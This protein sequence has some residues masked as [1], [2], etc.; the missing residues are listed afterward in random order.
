MS[1]VGRVSFLKKYMRLNNRIFNLLH[2]REYANNRYLGEVIRYTHSVEKG[3]SLEEVRLGFGL[4]KIKEAFSIIEKY[5]QNAGDMHNEVLVMFVDALKNY[6]DFHMRRSFTNSDVEE[7]QN[8]YKLLCKYVQ[9]SDDISSGGT[10]HIKRSRYTSEERASIEKLFLN[11]HSVRDFDGSSVNHEKLRKAVELAMR[12]PSAC[13]RQCYRMY[14]VD[15]KKFGLLNKWFDGIGGFAD[16]LDKLVFVTGKISVYRE[17]EMMQWVVTGS[18]FASY[19]T[20]AFE[21]YDIGCCFIQRDVFPN[22]K[23]ETVARNLN[24]EG[25]EQVVCCLGIGNLKQ[26]YDVPISHRLSIDT[27]AKFIE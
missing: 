6:L 26:E 16:K 12:C 17:N 8:I 18:V 2:K 10:L 1:I 25:D 21:A 7:V 24:V 22:K 9:N 27:I 15:R 5:R 4:A 23:W 13:N 19:L 20:L 14:V 11:R 3:L